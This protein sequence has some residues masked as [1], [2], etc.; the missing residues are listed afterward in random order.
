MGRRKRGKR[1][2]QAAGRLEVK[3]VCELLGIS[4]EL[5]AWFAYD[6]QICTVRGLV[7]LRVVIIVIPSRCVPKRL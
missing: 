7:E 4:K 3:E 1:Q 5:R 6:Q 2:A